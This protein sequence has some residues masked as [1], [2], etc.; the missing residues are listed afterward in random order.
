[1]KIGAFKDCNGG[2]A[3]Y[4]SYIEAAYPGFFEI[5]DFDTLLSPESIHLLGEN[6]IEGLI[7]FSEWKY[8]EDFWKA[9]AGAGVKY[10]AIPAIG[11]EFV[12][13]EIMRRVGIRVSYVP[14][15]SPNAVAEHTVLLVLSLLRH[16]REQLLRIER[17][18]YYIDDLCASELRSMTVD[19]IDLGVSVVELIHTV[20]SSFIVVQTGDGHFVF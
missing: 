10:V 13:M 17:H 19:G 20:A 3:R 6:G 7:Y 2:G 15:Y 5:V 8:G 1:M 4:K 18:D 16:F 11:H 14:G 9:V 12:D